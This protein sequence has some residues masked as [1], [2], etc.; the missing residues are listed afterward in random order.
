MMNIAL[1][2]GDDFHS[3]M[4]TSQF[5]RLARA[6]GWQVRV[7][8]VVRRTEGS[9][10]ALMQTWRKIETRV[11]P[12]LVVALH[13]NARADCVDSCVDAHFLAEGAVHSGPIE[14]VN[15]PSFVADLAA[16]EQDLLVAIRCY[17]KFSAQTIEAFTRHGETPRLV[18]LH[19]GRLP[20]Y[21]GVVTYLHQLAR[22]DM[23]GTHS[24]HV[25]SPRW[26]D[27]PLLAISKKGLDARLT[28]TGNYFSAAASGAHLLF[29]EIESA[30]QSDI[31]R[32]LS[33]AQ[34][35]VD[36]ESGYHSGADAI[37]MLEQGPV[38]LFDLTELRDL[39]ADQFG[40]EVAERFTA[41]LR[42]G[43]GCLGGSDAKITANED[44]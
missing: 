44:A 31:N 43:C 17:Q 6:N 14:D 2:I 28:L 20:A 4:T 35:Q 16:S 15:A 23:H 37:A 26:D 29:D 21:R 13:N 22:R 33:T 36:E 19:P 5:L 11:F 41:N 8:R 42:Q 34:A 12:S 7:F 24:L 3:Q 25:I 32:Y 40:I 18:N 10:H 27:G 9:A 1:F 39:V 38:T 30:V